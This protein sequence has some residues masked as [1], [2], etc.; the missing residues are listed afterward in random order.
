M[1][2]LDVIPMS[3]GVEM[4]GGLM[5]VMVSKNSHI[6]ISRTHL[7]TNSEDH[8]TELF[9]NVYQGERRLVKDN[10]CLTTFKLCGLNEK[11]KRGEMNIRVTFNIDS[12]GILTVEAEETRSNSKESVSINVQKLSDLEASF[13][14]LSI[15]ECDDYIFEDSYKSNQIL[16]KLELY[17]TFKYLL[18]FYNEHKHKWALS[19]FQEKMLNALFNKFFD[20]IKH[21]HLYTPQYLHDSKSSLENDFHNIVLIN[22]NDNSDYYGSTDICN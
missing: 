14:Q 20:I 8:I 19:S 12:N 3:L 13:N 22:G 11:Y 16:N 9:I 4:I 17:D 5:N 1:T 21:F 7:Y 6:P 15:D 18:T 10:V 2:V